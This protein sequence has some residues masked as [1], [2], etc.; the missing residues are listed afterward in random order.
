VR[1]F[2]GQQ[3]ASGHPTDPLT[4]LQQAPRR[5]SRAALGYVSDGLVLAEL[6]VGGQLAQLLADRAS[7]A[8]F[9]QLKGCASGNLHAE[10]L[11]RDEIG[12]VDHIRDGALVAT[13]AEPLESA[14][15]EW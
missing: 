2:A 5:V 12:G 11:H 9:E 6:Y 8:A 15:G 4:A 13:T 3:L 7:Q 10:H 14:A 1:T